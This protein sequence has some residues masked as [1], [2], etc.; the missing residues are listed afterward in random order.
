MRRLIIGMAALAACGATTFAAEG[1]AGFV[2]FGPGILSHTGN[3]NSSGDTL[4]ISGAQFGGD[5][6][7]GAYFGKSD[8]GAFRVAGTLGYYY[9]YDDDNDRRHHDRRRDSS[10]SDIE[11]YTMPILASV[12]YEFNLS[13]VHLRL[14]PLAGV[15][16]IDWDWYEGYDYGDWYYRRRN[17]NMSGSSF[18]YG[19]L[20]G[21]S[22]DVNDKFHIAADYKFLCFTDNMIKDDKVHAIAVSFGMKF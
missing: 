12:A 2:E 3:I 17:V 22:F 15:T 18:T 10:K 19:G 1:A 16:H 11:G 14:G 13:P 6:T 21:L 7:V 8:L 4:K 9:S 20:L 5:V